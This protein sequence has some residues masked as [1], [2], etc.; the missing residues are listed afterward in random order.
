MKKFDSRFLIFVACLAGVVL[1]ILWQQFFYETTQREILNMQLET[2]RLREIE[3][4][5]TAL[6]S[7]HKN[8]ETFAQMKELE[9]DAARK[10]L[11]TTLAQDE[12]IDELYRAAEMSGVR[13]SAVHTSD[14]VE[15]EQIQSQVVTVKLEAKYISLLNFLREVLDGER[16]VNLKNFSLENTGG[17]V[18]SG[19]LELKIFAT[20]NQ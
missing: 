1:L 7:R 19:E 8:L 10:F 4:E 16:S 9:L 5:I 13:L 2:R 6:K 15:A 14:T 20:A 3:R 17:N 11:P 12:F 18:L